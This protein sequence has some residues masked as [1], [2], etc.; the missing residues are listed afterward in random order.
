MRVAIRVLGVVIGVLWVG[1]A[2]YYAQLDEETVLR[3]VAT[4][5]TYVVLGAAF[6]VYGI[7]GKLPTRRGW[8]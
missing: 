5:V 2:A 4:C 1:F 7:K 8:K 6:L 3:R